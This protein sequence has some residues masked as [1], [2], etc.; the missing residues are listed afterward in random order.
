MVLASTGYSVV[1]DYLN[2]K[3]QAQ[4]IVDQA[5]ASLFKEFDGMKAFDQDV[6]NDLSHNP[7]F[8]S[9]Y[10]AKDRDG[11]A[12]AVKELIANS[13][14]TGY[15]T[16]L[17]NNGSIFYSSETPAK[18]GDSVR[19]Q[20]SG[21][22]YVLLH[23]NPW[24]GPTAFSPTGSLCMSTMVPFTAGQATGVVSANI[25]LDAG[26]FTGLVTRLALGPDHLSGIEMALVNGKTNH[27]AS[28]TSDLVGKDGGFLAKVDQQGIKSIPSAPFDAG[29]RFWKP[30]ILG[31]GKELVGE[32]LL[33]SPM[34]SIMPKI[35]TALGQIGVTAAA[36]LVLAF[37]FSAGIA[38][39]V[40][41]CL[42]FLIQRARDLAAQRATLAPLEGLQ[43]EWL[44]L[45]EL[46]DTA[47]SS[48]RAS[49][50]SLKSQ[51]QRQDSS[52]DDRLRFA[53]QSNQQL[54][55]VNR[56]LSQ[57]TK[58]ITELSKQV[59]FAN[60]QTVLLQQKLDSVLQIS[61]E[62]FLLLD[63]FGNVLSANPVFLS[64]MGA[65]EG[66]IAGRQCFDLVRRPG[67]P[68]GNGGGQVFVRHGND[69]A[70]LITHFYPE[71]V[72]Y[73]RQKEKPTEV[74]AHLQPVVTD[75]S[76]IQG[77]I[78][79]LR[80]KSLRSEIAQLRSDIV[81]MLSESIRTPLAN[82]EPTWKRILSNASQTMHPSV[83]QTLAQIHAQYEQLTGIVDSL[84]MVY[85]GFVP[86]PIVPREEII[87]VRLVAECLEELAS[88][89]REH[90]LTL[91][92][93]TPTGLPAIHAD[94]DSLKRVLVALLEK[95]MRITSPGG[96][97]R[98]EIQI[99]TPEMRFSVFSNG[100]ALPQAE[101]VD[102]FV[103]FIQ[104]KHDESTYSDRLEMLLARNNVER[105][106]G[107]IWAESEEGRGTI[108][109]F[110]L[111]VS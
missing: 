109:F 52:V 102:M 27:V 63:Q 10:T 108:V 23:S 46:M 98:V 107:K 42:R 60:Q 90:Q 31:Q 97:V 36:A 74:L 28:T 17:D 14:F 4:K 91:E 18:F 11:V 6:A 61:T 69:P 48:L 1:L 22:D 47:V 50:Q 80:D 26:F 33:S 65:S 81:A 106:G 68:P 35:I 88:L 5:Q 12:K 59:N 94:R 84:L 58:Q 104:G 13:G 15:I 93:K 75:D 78:M 89:A 55:T 96:R 86:P 76:N 105:L 41:G 57:Q 30:V 70:D 7:A 73:H 103:G 85:G 72:I 49:V 66:E 83:G 2:T 39:Y 99:R 19:D 38:G 82:V 71:G 110:T 20:S 51:V 9:A 62:G 34:P 79:V 37:I 92:Q 8:I 16:V 21:I 54:E 43:G 45:G 101:V 25:P 67:D 32:I 40:N 100:P 3:N 44:E 87:V 111:P 95:M 53:E 56:Q 29:G 24:Q 77:Y 64:W